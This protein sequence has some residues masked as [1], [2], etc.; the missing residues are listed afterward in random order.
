MKN[1]LITSRNQIVTSINGQSSSFYQTKSVSF[2]SFFDPQTVNFLPSGIEKF[3][4]NI[5]GIEIHNASLKSIEQSDLKPFKNL[6][7]MWLNSNELEELDSNLFEHNLE[8]LY[9]NFSKNKLTAVGEDIFKPVTKL[10]QAFFSNNVCINKDVGSQPQISELASEMRLNCTSRKKN[11]C[12]S[13]ISQ[14][15]QK[16]LMTTEA[17]L[18]KSMAELEE[19]KEKLMVFE[20]ELSLAR[21]AVS[22]MESQLFESEAKWQTM[23]DELKVVKRSVLETLSLLDSIDRN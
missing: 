21:A 13:G 6:K 16:K 18:S 12:S 19:V 17:S 11:D 9:I 5:E 8:L 4:P 10:T 3:F 23:K 22:A 2:I 14:D 15:V 1:S 7:E 20:I